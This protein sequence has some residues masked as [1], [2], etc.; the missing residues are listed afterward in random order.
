MLFEF[1]ALR[2]GFLRS[3]QLILRL[4]EHGLITAGPPCGSFVFLNMGTSGR[5]TWRPLGWSTKSYVRAANTCLGDL[6]IRRK[7]YKD[8]HAF[9]AP[10]DAGDRA[11]RCLLDRAACLDFDDVFPLY[12]ISG[13]AGGPFAV[14]DVDGVPLASRLIFVCNNNF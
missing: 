10:V 4:Q 9:G 8:N 13:E 14:Y 5:R 3:I 11:A 1:V 6:I 12:Q 7:I 2:T